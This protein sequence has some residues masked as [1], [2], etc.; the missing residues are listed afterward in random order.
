MPRSA[1]VVGGSRGLGAGCVR[2]LARDWPV[3]AIG[4]NSSREKAEAV[5]AGL[6]D[7]CRGYPVRCDVRDAASV[8]AAAADV[9]EN[10]GPIGAVVFS[11]GCE[12]EQPLISEIDEDLWRAVLET[13]TLGFTRVLAAIL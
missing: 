13:E 12:I 11:A 8:Q 4:Y 3:V 5:A 9:V 7:G 1:W 10:C 6:P 2:A